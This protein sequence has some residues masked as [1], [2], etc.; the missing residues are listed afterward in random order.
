MFLHQTNSE[1]S[2]ENSSALKSQTLTFGQL[3]QNQTFSIIKKFQMIHHDH[4]KLRNLEKSTKSQNFQHLENFQVLKKM[5]FFPTFM[6][7]FHIDPFGI[8]KNSK[9]ESCSPCYKLSKMSKN[10]QITLSSYTFDFE[11]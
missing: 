7:I 5:W 8:R 2:D 4:K 11:T 1:S 10:L 9:H 6:A 3:F